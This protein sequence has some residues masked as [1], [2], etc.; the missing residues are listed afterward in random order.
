MSSQKHSQMT[1]NQGSDERVLAKKLANFNPTPL[2]ITETT[3][4][5]KLLSANKVEKPAR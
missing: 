5:L 1:Q 2:S 4:V 3:W